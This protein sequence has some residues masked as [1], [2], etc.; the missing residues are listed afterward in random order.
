MNPEP[1]ELE[2]P[3]AGTGLEA[4]GQHCLSKWEMERTTV[5]GCSL[6]DGSLD[7]EKHSLPRRTR[8][9]DANR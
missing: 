9:R 1:G 6:V 8:Y 7:G 5:D 4:P 3:S 2:S